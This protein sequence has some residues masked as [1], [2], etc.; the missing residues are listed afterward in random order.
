MEIKWA[1]CKATKCSLAQRSGFH[2]GE[3][4]L[5]CRLKGN[6]RGLLLPGKK[7]SR[8]GKEERGQ[9]VDAV[10]VYIWPSHESK[11]SPWEFTASNVCLQ[12]SSQA[13]PPVW[14]PAAQR[15]TLNRKTLNL[16]HVY[17]QGFFTHLKKV[18]VFFLTFHPPG[19]VICICILSLCKEHFK[20]QGPCQAFL[21]LISVGSRGGGGVW[22]E[23]SSEYWVEQ[24]R[25]YHFVF[26]W[27][28]D[29]P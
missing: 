1:W 13:L 15:C 17:F 22:Q 19:S 12:P 29:K 4:K 8:Q 25:K 2:L 14:P 28:K 3:S 27:F 24:Q 18:C 20:L 6:L 11:M 10:M 16:V 7:G 26:S 5:E 23:S 21:S 9:W